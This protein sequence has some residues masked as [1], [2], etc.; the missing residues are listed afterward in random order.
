MKLR[1]KPFGVGNLIEIA[2]NDKIVCKNTA[3]YK[4]VLEGDHCCDL[5]KS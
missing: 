5:S 4:M 3:K 2:K 1:S